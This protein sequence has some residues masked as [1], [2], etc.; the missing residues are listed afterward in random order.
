MPG[1]DRG[2]FSPN[3]RMNASRWPDATGRRL[4]RTFPAQ[5]DAVNR[6]R[7]HGEPAITVQIVKVKD[8]GNA[9]VGNV[10]Q[11]ASVIVSDNNP[12][13]AARNAPKAS[14]QGDGR[15][16]LMRGAQA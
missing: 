12:A 14:A 15:T 11:H 9:I 7:S 10:T 6:H 13:S 8:G 16:P 2:K 4:A 3:A 1:R 5:I